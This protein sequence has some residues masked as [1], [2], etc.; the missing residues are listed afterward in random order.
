M[1]WRGSPPSQFL[2]FSWFFGP[3]CSPWSSQ[4]REQIQATAVIKVAVAAAPGPRHSEPGWG[5]NLRPT[6]PRRSDP[7]V[8]QQELLDSLSRTPSQPSPDSCL[9]VQT[10]RPSGRLDTSLRPESF[11][12]ESGNYCLQLGSESEVPWGIALGPAFKQVGSEPVRG[13][14]VCPPPHGPLRGD[15]MPILQEGTRGREAGHA[16]VSQ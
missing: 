16:P 7:I 10:P 13:Q 11:P 8:L 9:K 1:T 6:V 3:P 12:R 2:T 15:S 14:G 5:S 4:A